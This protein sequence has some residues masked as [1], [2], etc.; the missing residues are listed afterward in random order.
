MQRKIFKDALELCNLEL[1]HYYKKID[2]Q[3]II[4]LKHPRKKKFKLPSL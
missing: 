4:K 1:R 3:A 2:E